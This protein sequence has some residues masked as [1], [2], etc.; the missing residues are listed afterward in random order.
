MV[1]GAARHFAEALG[2]HPGPYA[3][4]HQLMNAAA[5]MAT[6]LALVV[7]FA[8]VLICGT[9][10]WRSR[11]SRRASHRLNSLRG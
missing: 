4:W 3:H 10:L 11:R 1:A 9:L 5:S 8:V 7:V 6:V 2:D